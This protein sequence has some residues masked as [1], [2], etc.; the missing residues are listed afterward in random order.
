MTAVRRS[1]PPRDTTAAGLDLLGRIRRALA[2]ED[3]SELDRLLPLLAGL[4]LAPDP[5]SAGD[6]AGSRKALLALL[7]EAGQ[8]TVELRLQHGRL[9]GQLHDAGVHRRAGV[10]YRRAGKL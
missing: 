9:A 2:A 5:R 1:M 10:A 7:D 8:L 3:L 6:P 4:D